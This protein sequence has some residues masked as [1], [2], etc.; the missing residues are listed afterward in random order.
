MVAG[1]H[2]PIAIMRFAIG[3]ILGLFGIAIVWLDQ[4]NLKETL[5]STMNLLIL[6]LV[7]YVGA[8]FVR[9]MG[10]IISKEKPDSSTLQLDISCANYYLGVAVVAISEP[11]LILFGTLACSLLFMIALAIL[12]VFLSGAI[13]I[14]LSE[15]IFMGT[16]A[17]LLG[18]Y[19]LL[20]DEKRL[21]DGDLKLMRKKLFK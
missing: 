21:F 17:I 4:P 8:V 19:Y 7:L 10:V 5:G 14:E 15:R 6:F 13:K 12:N 3:I 9:F 16:Y 20:P 1:K 11:L 2:S 18:A